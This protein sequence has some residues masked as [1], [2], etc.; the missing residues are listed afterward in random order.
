V[1]EQTVRAEAARSQLGTPA[2]TE[3]HVSLDALTSGR[4]ERAA[5]IVDGHPIDAVIDD[6]RAGLFG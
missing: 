1:L 5:L 2:S 4:R 3:L 6:L